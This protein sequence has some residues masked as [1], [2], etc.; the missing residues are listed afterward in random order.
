MLFCRITP[1]LRSR[2]YGSGGRLVKAL[3]AARTACEAWNASDE[4]DN[5]EDF[6]LLKLHGQVGSIAQ[7]PP[8]YK[9]GSI[10]IPARFE[11]ENTHITHLIPAI[12]Q[13]VTKVRK[14][15]AVEGLVGEQ[16]TKAAIALLVS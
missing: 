9:A 12:D 2:I 7:I 5:F 1:T 14:S 10:G 6:I 13:L 16:Q 15:L 3:D 8:R 11:E 4:W